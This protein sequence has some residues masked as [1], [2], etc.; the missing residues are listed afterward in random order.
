[1]LAAAVEWDD[2]ML[3]A[4]CPAPFDLHPVDVGAH[5]IRLIAPADWTNGDDV[6]GLTIGD[7]ATEPP[8]GI[9]IRS[10]H[11]ADLLW[12]PIL[13]HEMGHALGLGHADSNPPTV[14]CYMDT[15]ST[16][17]VTETDVARA[18]CAMGCR[19]CAD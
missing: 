2:N 6:D 10:S 15:C 13:L 11:E 17:Y 5:P 9:E 8:G 1:M 19:P 16:T 14:M 4:G 3:A 7:A 18:A 12:R